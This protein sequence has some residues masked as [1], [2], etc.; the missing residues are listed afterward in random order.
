ME[1]QEAI[2]ILIQVAKLAQSKGLLSLEDANIVL[3]CVTLLNPKE[4]ENGEEN[5]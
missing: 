1:N 4:L 2:N 3:Q 5:N